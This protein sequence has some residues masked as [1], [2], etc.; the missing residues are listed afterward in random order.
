MK[1]ECG[2]SRPRL[3]LGRKTQFCLRMMLASRK[4][5]YRD[6]RVF[7]LSTHSVSAQSHRTCG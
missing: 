1:L 2:N 4:L 3:S 7:K 6:S 5:Y